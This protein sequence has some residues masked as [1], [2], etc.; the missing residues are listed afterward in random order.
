MKVLTAPT[1]FTH[2][3]MQRPVL[4]S[5]RLLF[6]IVLAMAAGPSA[7]RCQDP[8]DLWR[9]SLEFGFTGASGNTSFSILSA[10]ASLNRIHREQFEFEISGRVRWGKNDDEVIANDMQG[11]VK[12]DWVP[13]AAVSPFVYATASRDVIRNLDS[14][15]VAGG[16]AKW[17]FWRPGEDTKVSAS[18][19]AIVDYENYILEAGSPGPESIG[20]G[21]WSTRLKFDHTLGSGATF[22]HVTFWQ[23]RVSDFDDYLLD[24]STSISTKL[25][26][27]LSLVIKHSYMHDAVPPPGAVRDDQR[28]SI[29]L[30][31]SM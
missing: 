11:T 1:K 18:V 23:P 14:R 31:V 13:Q 10:G 25:V 30:R 17:T 9:S 12:F 6:A 22:Q 19:A 8:P 20:V 24:M 16:G 7:A 15:L 26:A 27:G 21:R 2:P 28:L 3:L 29:V 5:R 4:P